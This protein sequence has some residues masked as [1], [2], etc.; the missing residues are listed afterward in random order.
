MLTP[1]QHRPPR[2]A[3]RKSRPF[4]GATG[5]PHRLGS[6]D[7]NAASS[8]V[9]QVS[10]GCSLS[11]S[12]LSLSLCIF[13][14]SCFIGHSRFAC[15][16]LLRH[17][18]D[19]ACPTTRS[20]LSHP[21]PRRRLHATT[22]CEGWKHQCDSPSWAKTRQRYARR[23]ATL[24]GRR[25]AAATRAPQPSALVTRPR[26]PTPRSE[27]S[28]TLRRPPQASLGM[29]AAGR[30]SNGFHIPSGGSSRKR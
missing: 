26:I 6:G 20:R 23:F 22:G 15:I 5:I 4:H 21:N 11:P 13:L 7:V 28:T 30:T 18:G 25:I 19:C 3:A 12:S 2:P 17:F 9:G 10:V 1:R 16:G 29:R 14:S 8:P 27:L 24:S